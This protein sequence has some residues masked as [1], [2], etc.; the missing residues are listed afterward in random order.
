MIQRQ[1]SLWLLFATLTAFLSF[2]LPFYAGVKLVNNLPTSGEINGGTNFLLL[3]TTGAIMI[4]S[5]ITI[6]LFKN[7]R[8]QLRMCIVGIVLTLILLVFYFLEMKNFQSGSV[9]LSCLF[10][11]ATLA[12]F[13]LAARGVY[14][15]EKLVKSLDKLR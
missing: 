4:I 9:S 14:K 10:V 1:Q 2:K 7:R 15:D 12:G 5:L 11:F 8:L 13:I 3:V 6:F